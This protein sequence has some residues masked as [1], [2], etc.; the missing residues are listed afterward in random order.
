MNGTSGFQEVR[1]SASRSPSNR[2]LHEQRHR[3][4]TGSWQLF[5]NEELPL[6][7]PQVRMMTPL[8][9]PPLNRI[10]FVT[11]K[12]TKTEH[13]RE[14]FRV[15][16]EIPVKPE[17]IHFKQG[18]CE[19]KSRSYCLV[20]MLMVVGL[21]F[22]SSLA[23]AWP[24]T[25]PHHGRSASLCST[26]LHMVNGTH[27]GSGQYTFR[28]CRA[29]ST[30]TF[31]KAQLINVMTMVPLASCQLPYQQAVNEIT[32]NCNG[33]P[34]GTYIASLTYWVQGGG[35]FTHAHNYYVSP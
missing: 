3:F 4:G 5:P 14:P 35:P 1:S 27:T 10:G 20:A 13:V 17:V 31:W 25:M 21:F 15:S 12:N 29:A 33:I 24:D 9:P 32:F 11:Y 7:E 30:A 16:R 18:W 34:K 23:S 2:F 28:L 26:Q 8:P 22:T 6:M 19:M